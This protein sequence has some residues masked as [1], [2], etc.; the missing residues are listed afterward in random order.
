MKAKRYSLLV[1]FLASSCSNIG[2]TLLPYDRI[3]YNEALQ[4]SDT[5]QELLNIVRLRYSD[6]PYFLTVN[7]VVSQFS[8][9]RDA[10]VNVSNNLPPPSILATG[11]AGTSFSESPTITYTPLQGEQFVTR[12][13]TPIDLSVLYMLLRSGWGIN[14]VFRVLIQQMGAV[15]NAVIAS[16]ST[17]SRIPKFEK[18]LSLGIALRTLQHNDDLKISSSKRNKAFAIKMRITHFSRLTPRQRAILAKVDVSAEEPY[19]W[20]VSHYSTEPH[21]V[22]VQTRTVLGLLNYLSKGVDLPPEDIAKKQ[23]P[24]TYYRNGTLFDW[25]RVTIGMMRVHTSNLRP[26]NDYV[27]IQYK[28][29]WFYI[30]NDDF[31]SKETLNLMAIIMGIYSGEIKSFQPVFTVS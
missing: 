27:S 29:H 14:H 26:T 2:S 28:H 22:Y 24:M 19:F 31:E 30:P 23:A 16:R 7:N 1:F 21:D 18:F 3:T 11:N 5:Q 10:S 8:L 4:S 13:L 6:A 20:L 15:E 25:H 12:L 9:S 17:S